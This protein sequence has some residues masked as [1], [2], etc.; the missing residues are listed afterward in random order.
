MLARNK[1]IVLYLITWKSLVAL[2]AQKA[3]YPLRK[4]RGKR[5]QEKEEAVLARNVNFVL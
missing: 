5:M 2:V 3:F 1:K 4:K